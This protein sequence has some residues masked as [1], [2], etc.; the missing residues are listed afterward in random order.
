MITLI[1]NCIVF[2]IIAAFIS[3]CYAFNRS[4]NAE[5]NRALKKDMGLLHKDIDSFLGT[6]EPSALGER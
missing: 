5:H 2:L 6:T 1:K 3:G 4:H